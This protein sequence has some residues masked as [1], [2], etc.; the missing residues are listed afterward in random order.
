MVGL[1]VLVDFL[2]V[3]LTKEKEPSPEEE[4][5]TVQR[6]K[7]KC[8]RKTQKGKAEKEPSYYLVT[9]FE[10]LDLPL[11]GL[12]YFIITVETTKGCPKIYI[13]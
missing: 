8:L 6:H 10:S 9:Y 13:Y 5:N 11:F 2:I 1:V 3:L 7:M 4:N 12:L